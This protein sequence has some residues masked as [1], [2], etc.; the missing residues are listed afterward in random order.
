MQSVVDSN[1]RYQ[2]TDGDTKFVKKLMK[3]KIMIA[4]VISADIYTN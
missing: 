4:T 3:K 1:L 2:Y